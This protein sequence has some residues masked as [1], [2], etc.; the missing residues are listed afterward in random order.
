MAVE[1]LMPRL[2]WTMEEG[3]FV[4]WL[5]QDGEQVRPGDLLYTIEGD[6]ASNDIESFESGILRIPPDAPAP[7]TT[8]LVGALLGYIVQP[9]EPAPFEATDHRPPTTDMYGGPSVAASGVAASGVATPS[10]AAPTTNDNGQRTTDNRPMISP[11]ARRVARE[12]GVAWAALVGSGRTGRIVE[13]DVRA[14]ARAQATPVRASPLAR[15]V[16]EE[17]GVDI[18][19][20]ATDAPGRRIGRADVE[21][22]ARSA[23]PAPAA[24]TAT[25]L[26]GVRKISTARLAESARTVVPVTLTTDADATELA[27]L[28]KQIAADLASSGLPAPSYNDMLIKLVALA[29]SEHP[30]LNASFVEEGIVQHT[31]AHIG[32]AVDTDRGLLAPVV[33][34]AGRKSLQQIAADSARLIEQARMGKSLADD[35]RGGTFTIS[36]LGMYQIDA[37]T[38][39]INLPECAILGVGRIQ[40]RPV[41]IDEETD[42]VAVRRMLALSLT[43]DHRVVDGAPAARFLN[44]VREFI[45]RPY[46]WLIR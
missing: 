18:G 26:S 44:R 46:L 35:L 17:L 7:G 14:A 42:T 34:D 37:F 9:G 13:R 45:E 40:A 23:R 6:K 8:L 3:V 31:A 24:G 2:G 12:L 33:H 28:R 1:L 43:F 30:A 27:R 29:L 25:P 36:N 22:A 16:A 41:V 21:Q 19:Q 15:R 4:Q 32:V 10:V 11:R 39:V 5:K 20:L 38:P